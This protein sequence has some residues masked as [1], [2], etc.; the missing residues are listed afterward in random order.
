MVRG[1]TLVLMMVTVE[2]V[3]GIPGVV[4]RFYVI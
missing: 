2:K 3:I 4:T 1:Y